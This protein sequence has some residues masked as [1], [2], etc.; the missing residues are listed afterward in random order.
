MPA[1]KF[2]PANWYWAVSGS[3]TQVFSSASGGYVPVTNPIYV[4]WKTAPGN[5][6][7]STPTEA[8][9]GATLATYG[10]RPIATNVLSGYQDALTAYF[11]ILD[12]I[13][14]ASA[15]VVMDEDNKIKTDIAAMATAVAAAASLA[16]LKTRFA[17]ISFTPQRT[18]AQ[19]K[20]A[21]RARL[22][23]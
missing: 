9:L 2:I 5:I 14:R 12:N 15:L 11:D 16:D 20:T 19:I 3:T 1:P 22:G 18:A 8:M 21:I 17:A 13:S 6:T 23:T 4:A 7:Y 10:R